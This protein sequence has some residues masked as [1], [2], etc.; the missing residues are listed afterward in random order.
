MMYVLILCSIVSIAAIGERFI[1][2]F[3]RS[4]VPR[5][6]FME[7]IREQFEAKD[8]KKAL[9]ICD[10]AR[11][12]FA[13]VVACGLNSLQFDEKEISDALDREMIINVNDLERNTAIIGTIASTAV[14][15]GLLGTVWGI[16]GTFRDISQM[17][18]GGISVV[19]RGVSE[20]LVCTAAGL[21]SPFQPWPPIIIA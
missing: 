10:V 15:I 20:A 17:G 6:E 1:Y 3:K 13:A 12:P 11:T 7:S 9:V 4:R 16:M 19:I 2:Y 18:S 14:Y 5:N 8:T 21:L